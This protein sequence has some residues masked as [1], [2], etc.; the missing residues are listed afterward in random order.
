MTEGLKP[1]YKAELAGRIALRRFG[2]PDEV[3]QAV[4][5]LASDMSSY[6]SGATIHVN[7][8]EFLT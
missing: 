5:F 8:G 6:I 4:L 2:L 7:G 1:E 3:A